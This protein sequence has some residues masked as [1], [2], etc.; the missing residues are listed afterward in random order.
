MR[1]QYSDLIFTL[2][3]VLVAS[4]ACVPQTPIPIYVTPT[5]QTEITAEVTELESPVVSLEPSNTSRTNITTP[6]LMPRQT[7]MGPI[8][9]PDYTIP[10][11]STPRP[12]TTTP[13]EAYTPTDT[14]IPGTP[15]P[16]LD[17]ARMGVQVDYN[18]TVPE[19]ETILFYAQEL[20]VEWIKFQASWRFLQP[21]SPDDFDQ[22]YRLFQLHVQSAHKRGFKVL[23]S[24]AKA[25]NWARPSNQNEDG[26]PDNPQ[27]LVNFINNLFSRI[28]PNIDAIEVW[29][30]PNL[31]REWNGIYEFSGR[32]Y[33]QLF[34]PAYQAIRA[35]SPTM[36]IITA[37][38]APTGASAFSVNDRDYL[39]QM[40]DAGLANYRDVFV[41][42]HP[43]SWGNPPD[44][45][46]CNAIEGRG[47]DDDPHFFFSHNIED[48]RN[49]MLRNGHDVP[50]W[51]TE[52]GW[53]TWEGIESE[54]PQAWM[55]YN[56]AIDQAN[57]T[58]RAFEWAQQ[59]PY[60]GPVILW[61]L[62]FANNFLIEQRSELAAYSLFLPTKIRPLY[63]ILRDRAR[64]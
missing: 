28:G 12:P 31:Q 38:L 62:N 22:S 18:L 59:Q 44:A 19:W 25:P 63:Y 45:R 46:C 4:I 26:P 61:N 41:G 40:Y 50:M 29:N 10:P 49:I 36:P 35:Y 57:Y 14:P 1:R 54:P 20:G 5:P 43:Y 3:L 39:Q 6:T 30:E 8:I 32:G 37:G 33:M 53:A 13:T 15:I 47:W 9:G 21:N 64:P 58:V 27:D 56:S 52:I 51:I 16:P 7:F 60:I 17:P 34:A 11:T 24:I 2:L 55:V 48:Y 42:I 23:L